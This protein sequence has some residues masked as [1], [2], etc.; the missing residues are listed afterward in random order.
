LGGIC[1]KTSDCLYSGL[2][3]TFR[4]EKQD[5]ACICP[6]GTYF[7]VRTKSCVNFLNIGDICEDNYNCPINTTCKYEN[8]SSNKVCKC[9]EDLYYQVS[10]TNDCA[11]LKNYTQSC[12]Y[13]NECNAWLGLLCRN[14]RCQ[15]PVSHFYNGYECEQKKGVDAVSY[16]KFCFNAYECKNSSLVLVCYEGS[17]KCEHGK[18]FNPTTNLCS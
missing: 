9:S 13:S 1:N 15:C 10:G 7:S 4:P 18:T 11:I 8:L 6:K 5:H 12:L 3:C 2:L 17:C 14:N 16:Q